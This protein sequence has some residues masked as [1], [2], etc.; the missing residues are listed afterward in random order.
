MIY[1]EE[2]RIEIPQPNRVPKKLE[3]PL[4]E[5]F[6]VVNSDLARDNLTNDL[7]FADLQDL[8]TK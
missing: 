2:R 6:P 1:I 4:P 8:K 7:P 3:K 5:V